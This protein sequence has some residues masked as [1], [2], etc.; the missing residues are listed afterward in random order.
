MP[1]GEIK[2]NISELSTDTLYPSWSSS[3][4]FVPF[5][6]LFYNVPSVRTQ[7]QNLHDVSKMMSVKWRQ[8]NTYISILRHFEIDIYWNNSLFSIK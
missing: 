5:L 2:K 1:S 7:N 4:T 8:S 6:Q 3:E